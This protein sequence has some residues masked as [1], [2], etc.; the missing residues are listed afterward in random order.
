VRLVKFSADP[1]V[2]DPTWD[3]D[4]RHEIAAAVGKP[5]GMWLSDE[6][7]WGWKAWCE[8]EEFHPAGLAHATEFSLT[9]QANV[10][11]I[12]TDAEFE[13]FGNEYRIPAFPSIPGLSLQAIDWARLRSEYDGIII[14]PYRYDRRYDFLN[15]WYAGW[16]VASACIWNLSAIE[17]VAMCGQVQNHGPV[18]ASCAMPAGHE[19]AAGRER[20]HRG[21]SYGTTVM[22]LPEGAS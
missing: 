7:D 17:P 12:S 21:K 9:D 19:E 15:F 2:F 14:S 8:S 1:L 4:N 5:R 11:H 20:V 3:Y 18:T 6:D 13:A 10:L 16:D 22:W